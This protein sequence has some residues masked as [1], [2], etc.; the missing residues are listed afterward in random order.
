MSRACTARASA[1]SNSAEQP[2]IENTHLT[3]RECKAGVR[4]RYPAPSV[5]M[6]FVQMILFD[7]QNLHTSAGHLLVLKREKSRGHALPECKCECFGRTSMV[8]ETSD[9]ADESNSSVDAKLLGKEVV[10]E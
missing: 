10:V 9:Q 3:R 4:S 6:S 2:E 7:C 8:T 1:H 5:P